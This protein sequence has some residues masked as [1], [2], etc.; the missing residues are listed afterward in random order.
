MPAGHTLADWA[1]YVEAV[2]AHPI[3][4]GGAFFGAAARLADVRP[5]ELA[6]SW[7]QPRIIALVTKLLRCLAARRGLLTPPVLSAASASV[8]KEKRLLKHATQSSDFMAAT[9]RLADVAVDTAGTWANSL[10]VSQLAV[11]QQRFALFCPPFW[12]RLSGQGCAG[13]GPR[14]AANTLHAY[15]TLHQAKLVPRADAR[16]CAQLA[17]EVAFANA[18]LVPQDVSN[19]LWAL[20]TLG[21]P[22]DADTLAALC[23]AA[24]RL[25]AHMT[26]QGVSNTLWALGSL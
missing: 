20:A 12:D 4:P 14:Q 23:A 18:D 9:R 25:A 19:T 6:D 15:A 3:A 5:R 1:E 11:S 17:S 13:L 24:A 10:A 21:M 8:S 16:L 2:C 26:P 22:V 7:T